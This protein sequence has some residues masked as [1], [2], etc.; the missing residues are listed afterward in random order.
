MHLI[1]NKLDYLE[2]KRTKKL[3]E[4][5]KMQQTIIIQGKEVDQIKEKIIQGWKVGI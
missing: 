2:P 1:E 3:S 5:I 4:L